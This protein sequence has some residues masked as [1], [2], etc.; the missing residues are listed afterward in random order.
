MKKSLF[1]PG[2]SGVVLT[3]TSV[4]ANSEKTKN[5]FI[6]VRP[7]ITSSENKVKSQQDPGE[8]IKGLLTQRR[9][10]TLRN[11]RDIAKQDPIDK[12]IIDLKEELAEILKIN[13]PLRISIPF[14]KDGSALMGIAA[15]EKR[16]E[17]VEQGFLITVK[18]DNGKKSMKLVRASRGEI[19]DI[20]DPE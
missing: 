15:S 18:Q 17:G 20:P 3:A 12:R 16:P 11:L 4:N 13:D 2:F 1:L 6:D 8:Q 5:H 9:K 14:D 7:K 10:E 19:I